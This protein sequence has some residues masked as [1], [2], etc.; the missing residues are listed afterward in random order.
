MKKLKTQLMTY[1]FIGMLPFLSYGQT[2]ERQVISFNGGSHQIDNKTISFALG[3]TVISTIGTNNNILT[4]GF[5]QPDKVV[6]GTFS[7]NGH[8][9]DIKLFPNPTTHQL[10]IELSSIQNIPNLDIQILNYLGQAVS[11][12]Q[13]INSPSTQAIDCQELPAGYYFLSIKAPNQQKHEVLSFV[14][15][16]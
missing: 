9:L 12:V 6:V 13:Q 10:N 3:E 8:D 4:Q 15:I 16:D 14:K 1:L 2:I 7:I 5:F 11:A